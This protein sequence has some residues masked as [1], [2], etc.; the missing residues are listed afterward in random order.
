MRSAVT[1]MAVAVGLAGAACGD[2]LTFPELPSQLL[3]D[4]CVQGTATVG[5]TVQGTVSASDCDAA[6]ARPGG[7]GYYD[8]W[9]VRVSEAQS[10]TF[11]AD[12]P[13]DNYLTLL[14]LDSFTQT[15]ADLTVVDENDDRAQGNLNALLSFTLQPDTDYF[16]AI[17][18]FDYD[19]T[20]SYSLVIR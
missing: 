11:D 18:G 10:V 6:D 12:S 15:S 9:R 14:R 17:S 16:I 13:F 19:E 7:V 20:G 8:V 1:T 3:A 2:S 5:E 4:F